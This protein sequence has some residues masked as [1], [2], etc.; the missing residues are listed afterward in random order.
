MTRAW[1]IGLA[2]L[3]VALIG[4]AGPA[5][6]QGPRVGAGARQQP[7]SKTQPVTFTADSVT[8]D[9][10]RAQ[11]IATGHVEA[12][13]NDHVLRADRVVFDRNT[14]VATAIGHVVLLEPD[15]EVLFAERAELTQGMREAVLHGMRALLTQNGRIAAEGARRTD[16]LAN[17]LS[18]V[19]Y[20]ACNL[21]K[22]DPTAPP[23]W[24]VHASSA[25]QN[26]PAQRME[27][28]DATMEIFGVPLLYMPYL[29]A[30]DPSVRRASGFMIPDFGTTTFL[31]QFLQ[32]PYYWVIDK[33]SDLTITGLI[34]TMQGP[35]LDLLYRRVFNNGSIKMETAAA[36][37]EGAMQGLMFGTGNFAYDDT[38]R[39]GFNVN[40][41]SSINYL[42]DFRLPEYGQDV[43]TSNLFTEGFGQG[44][45]ARLETIYYQGLL[46][47]ISSQQMPLVLPRYTYNYVG[48]PDAIGGIT[49]V[50][51]NSFNVLRPAGA[52]DQQAQTQLHYEL[53]YT[54]RYGDQWT[55]IGDLAAVGYNA[56]G[57][58]LI[59]TYSTTG[60]AQG[61]FAMPTV[62][63]RLDWPFVRHDGTSSIIVEP[64][65]QALLR[66]YVGANT[67]ARAP[68]EDALDPFFTDM[69]LFSLNR[70]P[71]L[72]RLGGGPRA[73]VGLHL[74]WI[75][76][77]KLVDALVGQSYRLTPENGLWPAGSGL[78]GTTSDIVGHVRVVPSD[79]FDIADRFR[80]D[81]RN[82]DV[83][84]DDLIAGFG[85]TNFRI[86]AGYIYSNIEPFYFL[87][88]PPAV[89]QPEPY[90][91]PRNE[92]TLGF[93]SKHGPFKL[94][95]FAAQNLQTGQLVE[96]GANASY[97]N[98]CFILAFTLFQLYT[99]YNGVS[100]ITA[101]TFN[102]TFKTLGQFRIPAL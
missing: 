50:T 4:L 71:G 43:L 57:L 64:I 38:W 22:D 17:E 2:A 27:F 41:A 8:Y 19:M 70:F 44:S 85:P 5:L 16:G 90:F 56:Y 10:E 28:E 101:A 88:N 34:D 35:E 11:I 73:D 24:Q 97:E 60:Q 89:L 79:W 31:G 48:K 76:D 49:S 37:D 77:G 21:C 1:R 33:S 98:E 30:P 39:Y 96:V 32:V 68:N 58:D 95:M 54:G 45:Y 15:G 78:A 52:S 82:G 92:I 53:P 23:L 72:D 66:P 91:L 83:A 81:H 67:Y 99:S 42:R 75:R 6:A 63:V 36:Y 40:V 69:N 59:P 18:R 46:Q 87:D 13:Q 86:N 62:A 3:L 80:L 100:N 29:S 12:W 74:E 93:D 51:F 94:G 61:A 47:Q 20:S 65:A 26:I 102:F 9:R 84:F 14:D 25:V 7:L 55:L